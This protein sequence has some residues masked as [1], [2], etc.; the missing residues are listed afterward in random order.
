MPFHERG[1]ILDLT[2][3]VVV[4]SI[5]VQGLTIRSGFRN[6]R[7]DHAKQIANEGIRTFCGLQIF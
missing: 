1:R 2:F 6:R 5:L 4:F 7:M 3:G